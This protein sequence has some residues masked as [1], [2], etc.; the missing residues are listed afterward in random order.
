M[1]VS[2]ISSSSNKSTS[3]SLVIPAPANIQN[4]DILVAFVAV[5]R[6]TSS[7]AT[8]IT[9]TGWTQWAEQITSTRY[10]CSLFWKRANGESGSYTFN[11]ASATQL[12]G[13]IGVYRGC[14]TTGDPKDVL[15]NTAYT[16]SGTTVR[17]AS[18]TPTVANGF[19]VF[20]GW[21]YLS[22]TISLGTPTGMN[23]RETQTNTNCAIR[24]ADLAST[25]TAASG[26]KD[27][28][29]GGSCTVKHA[30]MVAL[31]PLVQA[32]PTV[33]LNTPADAS[34]GSNA[35]P[36]LNFTGTDSNADAVEYEVQVD[37]VN[38]FDSNAVIDSYPTA[39]C[40]S[41]YGVYSTNY[42][43]VGQ[44]F[45]SSKN[46]KILSASFYLLN[47]GLPT[48]NAVAKLYT[49]TGTYGVN[50][51]PT[52][53]ALATSDL[54]D[55]TTV[56]TGVF[57]LYTFN[58]S[59]ANQFSMVAGTHYAIMMEYSGGNSANHLNIGTDDTTLGHAGN[60]VTQA[61]ASYWVEGQD[62]I[63]YVNG[64]D[65]LD[66]FSATDN[67]F[68][69]GHPFASGTAIDYTVQTALAMPDT[70]YWRV[71]A[72]DPAGT[73]SYGAWSAIR[74]FT[75][76]AGTSYLLKYWSGTAWAQKPLKYYTGSTWVSK[77]LKVYTGS[78]WITIN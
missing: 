77:P 66:V 1:A 39:N 44:T 40:T 31:K 25:T 30:F 36:T 76:S 5:F 11:S 22:G 55:T 65:L 58:F 13:A 38:T 27:A 49:I 19:F 8:S 62:C 71:R 43:G 50:A 20:G 14:V 41:S 63:F 23:A 56:R 37:T 18:C 57:T 7:T 72:K 28:T 35:T 75:V 45:T 26:T 59:G 53:S 32:S 70:Y 48:G 74:S 6:G 16:T 29:A 9:G 21:Y 51:I 47:T 61:G 60:C 15:S 67:G 34:S 54:F 42:T 69:A 17:A 46:A 78:E 2:F 64:S 73:N 24:L 12:Q 68:T 4:D 33:E 10:K 52:G 3:A